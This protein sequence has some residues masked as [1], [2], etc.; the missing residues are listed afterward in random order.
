MKKFYVYPKGRDI[1]IEL[2]IRLSKAK[3]PFKV[4][5]EFYPFYPSVKVTTDSEKLFHEMLGDIREF[6]LIDYICYSETKLLSSQVKEKYEQNE[7]FH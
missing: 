6:L 2:Y 4:T 7:T 1:E 3:I 5:Y